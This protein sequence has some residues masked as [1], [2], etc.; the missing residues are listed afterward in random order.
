[1]KDTIVFKNSEEIISKMSEI[2]DQDNELTLIGID[3]DGHF[4]VT[5][6]SVDNKDYL[7]KLIPNFRSYILGSL[8]QV[9]S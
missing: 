5:V 7:E 1:M 2:S 6:T 9:D 3:N 8:E 4:I